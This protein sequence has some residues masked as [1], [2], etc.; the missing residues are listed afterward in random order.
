MILS[1][2]SAAKKGKE[3]TKGVTRGRSPDSSKTIYR[4]DSTDRKIKVVEPS[5]LCSKMANYLTHLK[6]VILSGK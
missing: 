6:I 3:M 4:S 2:R 1:Y 5:K